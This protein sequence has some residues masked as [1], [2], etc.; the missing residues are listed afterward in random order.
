MRSN[1]EEYLKFKNKLESMTSNLYTFIDVEAS[2]G[3]ETIILIYKNNLQTKSGKI[4]KISD[5]NENDLYR[6]AREINF[7]EQ[8]NNQ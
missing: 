5:L 6:L 8:L 3:T 1:K 2:E 7:L 4:L